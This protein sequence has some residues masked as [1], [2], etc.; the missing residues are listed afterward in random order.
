MEDI[1]TQ[2]RA[3]IDGNLLSIIIALSVLIVGSLVALLMA[4][5]VRITLRRLHMDNRLAKAVMNENADKH[6]A[7]EHLAAKGT[8][9]LVMLF[10]L[11]AFFQTL[12][13]KFI[14][15]P[16]NEL[17]NRI[18]QFAPR[19]IGAGLLLLVAWGIARFMRT[20]L[21]RSL[22]AFK[23]DERL[24]DKAGLGNDQSFPLTRTLT[25]AL[26]WLVFLL[27]LPAI[28][29]TLALE[30]LLSPVQEMMNQVMGFLPNFF[31]AGL[32]LASGWFLARIVQRVITNLLSTIGA[33]N[34][35][36]QTGLAGLMG[37]QSLSSLVGLVVY[38]LILIPV[39]IAAL[40]ALE[41]QSISL[42][43]SNMLNT[44][45]AALPILFSAFLLIVVAYGV[46][47]V[48]ARFVT[49]LLSGVG[50][51]KLP[52]H[53]GLRGPTSETRHTPSSVVGTI[54]LFVI[55]L[56][57]GTEAC[58]MLGFDAIA[59]LIIQFTIFAGQVVLGLLIFAAGLFLA[60]IV[61]QRVVEYDNGH[62]KAMAFAARSAIL[63]FSG[64]MALQQM[65]LANELISMAFTLLLGALAVAAA[66]AFGLGGR[67]IA[68]VQLAEWKEAITSKQLADEEDTKKDTSP[69]V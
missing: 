10:V 23:L 19:L 20:M 54:T 27:F 29:S 50:F 37:S 40:N 11:V 2:F 35:G 38:I 1:V 68:A 6:V 48:I 51:D 12:E 3:M 33:D 16:L 18:F 15:D 4:Y 5:V 64:A 60:N 43:V 8:F 69:V 32:I 41:L 53:L 44:I 42:P 21:S 59:E 31:A 52:G 17:L 66:I 14:T 56:F 65:G 34:L 26:Y 25:D 57:A 45:L 9:Y 67:E 62:A 63:I 7:V 22:V 46:G 39:L 24:G 28:L 36:E 55:L 58:Q 49:D 30:G 61:S 13:L 47:R